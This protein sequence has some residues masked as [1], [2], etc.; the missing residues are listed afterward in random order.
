MKTLVIV[1]TFNG[2]RWIDRCLGSVRSSQV[3]A[4][5]FVFDNAST[6]GTPAYVKEHF[7][8]AILVESGSNLGF[9]EGNNAGFRYAAEHSYDF[10]YLLNQDAWFFPDTLASLQKVSSAHP[11]FGILSPCQ[12]Q[13]DGV[14]YNPVFERD[15]LS[16]VKPA[17]PGMHLGQVPFMMAAHWF[18]TAE[19]LRRVGYFADIFP[20]YGNDDNY[21]HRVL[22]HGFKIG[23]V[24]SMKVIHDKQYSVQSLDYR[25]YRNF[26][27]SALV[28]L[29]DVR[30]PLVLCIPAVAALAVVKLCK[31]RSAKVLKYLGSALGKDMPTVRRIRRE[32][33]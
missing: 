3:P 7:P 20:I 22:H 14:S 23:L 28:M 30:Y 2:M 29:C 1:V 24:N 16:R 18:M 32:T 21:C 26:Y 12:M 6:D 25:M 11:E 8:E 10:V 31:Y 33:R 27:M 17:D 5:A 9:A 15:V 13:A 4:D 19:C